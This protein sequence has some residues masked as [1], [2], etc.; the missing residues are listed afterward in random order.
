MLAFSKNLGSLAGIEAS[1]L[2]FCG[3]AC[4]CVC[5]CACAALWD[6]LNKAFG[7][8]L[9]A[10]SIS[11]NISW[12][13]FVGRNLAGW[14]KALLTLITGVNKK[15]KIEYVHSQHTQLLI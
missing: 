13:L 15:Q 11:L 1:I 9:F 14:H 4:A 7:L 8:L 12:W 6:Y 2:T 5:A 10:L 3:C